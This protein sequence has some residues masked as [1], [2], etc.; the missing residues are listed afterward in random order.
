MTSTVCMG[1]ATLGSSRKVVQLN[2]NLSPGVAVRPC[3]DNRARDGAS[4]WVA[5]RSASPVPPMPQ[6][7]TKKARREEW[8]YVIAENTADVLRRQLESIGKHLQGR[9]DQ[10]PLDSVGGSELT[11]YQDRV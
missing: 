9:P 7:S 11:G 2:I 10:A 8:P 5:E 3:D 6:R 1:L 4:I